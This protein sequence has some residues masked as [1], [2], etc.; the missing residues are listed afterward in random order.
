MY[1]MHSS[2]KSKTRDDS[3]WS[4]CPCL[5]NA[6]MKLMAILGCCFFSIIN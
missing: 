6:K 2:V 1:E 3:H 4:P 5:M